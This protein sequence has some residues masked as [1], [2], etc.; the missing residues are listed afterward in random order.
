MTVRELIDKLNTI[1]N[2]EFDVRL[3]VCE[4]GDAKW[5]TG[6]L[7]YVDDNYNE[8]CMFVANKMDDCMDWQL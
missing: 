5:W 6:M 1:P 7:S 3:S 8:E 2:K 4:D